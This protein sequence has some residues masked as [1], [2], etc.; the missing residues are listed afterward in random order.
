MLNTGDVEAEKLSI[1]P[2]DATLS[3]ELRSRNFTGDLPITRGKT[4]S[5]WQATTFLLTRIPPSALLD[6]AQVFNFCNLILLGLQM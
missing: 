5:A 1:L 2:K 4:L 3:P 6:L